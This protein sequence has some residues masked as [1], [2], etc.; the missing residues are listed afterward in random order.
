MVNVLDFGPRT[1]PVG[2]VFLHATGFN[3]L[4]YQILLAPLARGRRVLALDQRGHG[5]TSL[6][7][8]TEGRTTWLDMR[9]DLLALLAELEL[10]NIV[11]AG[12]SMGG[13]VALLAAAAAPQRARRLVL[14]EP[15]VASRLEYRRAGE[16]DETGMI[17]AARRRRAEFPSRAAVMEAYRGRGAFRTWPEA[18]LADYVE[19]GFVDLPGGGVR[20]ACDPAW[21]ASTYAAQAH[22]TL[23][24]FGQSRCPIRILKAEHES[25]CRLGDHEQALAASGRIVIE[26]V[27]GATHFLPMERPDLARAALAEALAAP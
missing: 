7:T 24:A 4:T 15:V 8:V 14:L 5:A 17:A 18:S 26:T 21:E 23:G 27:E 11:L 25:T 10:T 6:A 13:T 22:D 20:L 19:G 3:A 12:H 16:M 2:L 1:S 9:D